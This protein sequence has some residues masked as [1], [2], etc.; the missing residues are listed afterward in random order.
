MKRYV[1]TLGIFHTMLGQ[2]STSEFVIER[3]PQCRKTGILDEK[4]NPI[5]SVDETAPVGF[6]RLTERK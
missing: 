4:G 3:E 5:Y 6:V 1:T 2:A